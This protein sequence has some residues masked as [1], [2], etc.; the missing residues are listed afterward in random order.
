MA[1]A[2]RER[3]LRLAEAFMYRHHPQWDVVRKLL[4][5]HAIG[6]VRIVRAGL[7]LTYKSDSHHGFS[8]TLGGGALFQ[9]GCYA[10]DC[11]RMLLRA[12]PRRVVAQADLA[13]N[14]VATTCSAI[15]EFPGGVLATAHGSLRSADDQFLT[16]LGTRG[17]IDVDLPFIPEW[18]PTQIRLQRDDESRILAVG[19]A[20]HFL[21][22]VEHFAALV[23]DP[24]RPTFPAE[25]GVANVTVCEA[26]AQS[27]QSGRAIDLAPR[28]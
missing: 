18:K 12:E 23:L 3:G 10:V 19:G 15:L 21:H 9:V 11:V 2:F 27:Y 17:R 14:G 20:N 24:K 26:I 13:P 7:G 6:D 28:S 16:I 22:Q 4:A 1:G 5:D 8:P 25:D